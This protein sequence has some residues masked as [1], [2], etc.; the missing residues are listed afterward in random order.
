[1][2]A[3]IAWTAGAGRAGL[4]AGVVGNDRDDH[5]HK[6]GDGQELPERASAW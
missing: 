4:L 3:V 1:M 2:L 6:Q 5:G